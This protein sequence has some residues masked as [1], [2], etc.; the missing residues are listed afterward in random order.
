MVGKHIAHESYGKG[1]RT[2]Q[3]TDGFNA[4]HTTYNYNFMA[5]DITFQ[6]TGVF[7]EVQ[8]TEEVV[9]VRDSLKSTFQE[10]FRFP[11]SYMKLY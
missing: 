9:P 2:R 7:A 4:K 8:W 10:S 11:N 5:E 3:V 6:K 1:H